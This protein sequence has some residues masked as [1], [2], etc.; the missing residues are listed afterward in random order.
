MKFD[1]VLYLRLFLANT[2]KYKSIPHVY[3]P[4][5]NQVGAQLQ[6]KYCV[7]SFPRD[8]EMDANSP[9][10]NEDF[11]RDSPGVRRRERLRRA[12]FRRERLHSLAGETHPRETSREAEKRV[13]TKNE[14]MK[15]KKSAVPISVE[16]GNLSDRK[17][18]QKVKRWLVPRELTGFSRA[19]FGFRKRLCDPTQRG[20]AIGSLPIYHRIPGSV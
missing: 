8:R 13:S 9:T 18:E 1:P 5:T 2:K 10:A 19:Q 6:E 15:K 4:I 20:C 11:R 12:R 16:L 14:R 7:A 17:E 3:I